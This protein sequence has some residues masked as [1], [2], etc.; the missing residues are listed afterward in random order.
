MKKQENRSKFRLLSLIVV[1]CCIGIPLYWL[2]PDLR[3]IAFGILAFVFGSAFLVLTEEWKESKLKLL[4]AVL[5]PILLAIG[6]L[7]TTHGWNLRDN[8]LNER[9]RLAAMATELELN[10][11]RIHLL[12]LSYD[13]Y[14]T[15]KNSQEMTALSLLTTHQIRQV[16]GFSDSQKNDASLANMVFE[17]VFAADLLNSKLVQIDR[18]CSNHIAGREMVENLIQSTFGKECIFD[19]FRSLHKKLAG[20]LVVKYDWCYS[21]A[22]INLRKPIVDSFYGAIANGYIQ[23]NAREHQK[24]MKQIRDTM[25]KQGKLIPIPNEDLNRQ[26]GLDPNN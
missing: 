13:E 4:K 10:L 25:Q 17:Y 24:R 18:T 15:T 16:L 12:S 19:S 8:Y 5:I 22:N 14:K 23:L 20:H 6:G 11:M 26:V 21:E 7:L 1:I 9:T 3:M 2:R